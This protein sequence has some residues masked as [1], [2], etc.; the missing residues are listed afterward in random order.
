MSIVAP[1]IQSIGPPPTAHATRIVGLMLERLHRDHQAARARLKGILNPRQLGTPVGQMRVFERLKR[2]A[3]DTAIDLKIKTGK[4]GKFLLMLASWAPATPDGFPIEDESLP[5]GAGLMA[6]TA[7]YRIER[8]ELATHG[9]ATLTVS[10][11]ALVRM[12][13]RAD[14]RDIPEM[15]TIVRS[16]WAVATA[17]QHAPGEAWKT[18]PRRGW[19]TPVSEGIAVLIPHRDGTCLAVPTILGQ[20]MGNAAAIAATMSL[21]APLVTV[22]HVERAGTAEA[23]DP[24]RASR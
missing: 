13:E 5:H 10:R 1:T 14:V 15:L 4:R 22:S 11:H 24:A 6:L 16:L 19:Q 20:E 7:S 9:G 18:P 2:A 8:H 23:L 12:A 21:I 17:L 3:G